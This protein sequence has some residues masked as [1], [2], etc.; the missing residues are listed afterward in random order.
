MP[1]APPI[2]LHALAPDG[3]AGGIRFGA[4]IEGLPGAPAEI[5]YEVDAP[6]LQGLAPD[7]APYLLPLLFPAMA[8]GRDV[9]LDAP[10]SATLLDGMGDFQSAWTLW[11]P[12]RYR[13]VGL[14]V[15]VHPRP[16][17]VREPQAY[18]SLFSGGLDGCYTLDHRVR[19]PRLAPAP[20]LAGAVFVHGL[21]IPLAREQ[22]A[23]RAEAAARRIATS[24]GLPL[25][26]VRTNV[27]ALPLHWE[28]AHGTVLA[29]VL[30]LFQ[31]VFGGGWIPASLSPLGIGDA[32]GSHPAYD[33]LLSSEHFHVR[34]DG[35][36]ASRAEKVAVLA[37]W[38]EA[39]ADL[40]VCYRA[41]DLAAN[42]QRCQKCVLTKCALR[43][44]SIPLEGSLAGTPTFRQAF[45][46]D[47]RAVW[48]PRTARRI[49]EQARAHGHV[50]E[51]WARGLRGALLFG[52]LLPPRLRGAPTAPALPDFG[53]LGERR[54]SP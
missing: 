34:P 26:R 38:P 37:D 6:D 15:P 20:R 2:R 23:R 3:G 44:R 46:L 22:E 35:Q 9:T 16:P 36:E 33:P 40:R 43:A 17:P 4:R 19:A 14:E 54:G 11:R 41:G 7:G 48:A 29:A 28:D 39:R 32:W 50:H 51:G 12:R 45:G 53:E 18:V 42:C 13:R 5:F 8:A 27:R 52:R 25:W 24:V 47:L 49:L 31:G 1:A 10:S 30:H 21:D